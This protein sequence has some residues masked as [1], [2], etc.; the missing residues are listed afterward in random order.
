MG[1]STLRIALAALVLTSGRETNAQETT[2]A[3]RA[4][5][6]TIKS[7]IARGR[8]RS[9]TFR[10]LVT[11]LGQGDVI[12]YVQFSRCVAGV[13]ACLLWA[14]ARPGERRL[15]VRLDPFGRSENDL[16][17]L[18]AHELQ[19]AV[20]VASAPEVADAATFRQ[21]FARRG[22][23]GSDGFETAAAR[24]VTRKVRAELIR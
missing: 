18:L 11:Q 8:E 9:T 15:L 22:W 4:D 12:V 13:P 3:I 2:S 10:N 7:L 17:A 21:L 16:A 20:E 5:G 23:K 1:R 24:D 6:G 19:H 14:S